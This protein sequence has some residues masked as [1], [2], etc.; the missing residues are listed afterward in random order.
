M[1]AAKDLFLRI[2]FWIYLTMGV[3]FLS[4]VLLCLL[5]VRKTQKALAKAE[6]KLGDRDETETMEASN[7]GAAGHRFDWIYGD[8]RPGGICAGK[9]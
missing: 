2:D 8:F 1:G 6:K 9:L 5:P 3:I 4:G 7:S